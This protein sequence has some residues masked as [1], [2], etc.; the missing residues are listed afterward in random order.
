MFWRKKKEPEGDPN[1]FT[2]VLQKYKKLL[3]LLADNEVVMRDITGVLNELNERLE[4]A[5]E[6]LRQND[7]YLS[8]VN[9]LIEGFG[10]KFKVQIREED[11]RQFQ[12]F[13]LQMDYIGKKSSQIREI[14][15]SL[16]ERNGAISE[17]LTGIQ[18][19]N[20]MVMEQV[21]YVIERYAG[22]LEAMEEKDNQRF[23]TL[24]EGKE[25]EGKLDNVIVEL[26]SINENLRAVKGE[27][28]EIGN[29][30]YELILELDNY[31]HTLESLDKRFNP[32]DDEEPEIITNGN[33]IMVVM[34]LSDV[35]K[36]DVK[37]FLRGDGH[38][39][40]R[41]GKRIVE[42]NLPGTVKPRSAKLVNGTLTLAFDKSEKAQDYEIEVKNIDNH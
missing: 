24:S 22:V 15:N 10:L 29:K 14:L 19:R 7:H 8:K 2:S 12:E 3:N 16:M 40:V 25:I 6:L 11:V 28:S 37:V 31:R 27:Y 1:L 20:L 34:A 35:R 39:T 21:R 23:R 42:L 30:V 41:A 17:K 36:E 26:G 13:K 38:L 9:S 5:N 18:S 32:N 4:K 33:T